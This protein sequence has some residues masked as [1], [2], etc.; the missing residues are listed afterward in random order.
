MGGEHQ[1]AS[2]GRI[3]KLP[4]LLLVFST[5]L[6]PFVQMRGM[7]L[8]KPGSAPFVEKGTFFPPNRSISRSSLA[9]GEVSLLFSSSLFGF[10]PPGLELI[11]NGSCLVPLESVE[12]SSPLA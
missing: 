3:V 4:T 5:D 6:S 8:S 1:A 11:F 10:F 12:M 7:A 2:S 9:W